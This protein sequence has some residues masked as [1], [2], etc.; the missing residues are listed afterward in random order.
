MT[1]PDPGVPY[2]IFPTGRVVAQQSPNTA[3]DVHIKVHDPNTG[4]AVN[5]DGGETGNADSDTRQVYGV[6]PL[7]FGPFV[8]EIQ[9]FLTVQVI[10]TD[11]PE[12]G[13]AYRGDDVGDNTL[14]VEV[15]PLPRRV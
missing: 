5:W 13:V 11:N 12:F 6:P 7:R 8:G 4:P 3:V 2:T 1:I 15:W 14:S 10:R 9:V